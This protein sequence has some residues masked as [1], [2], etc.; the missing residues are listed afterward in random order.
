MA[1]GAANW[2][3]KVLGALR[4]ELD[5]RLSTRFKIRT[6]A[7]LLR[8][9]QRN[10]EPIFYPGPGDAGL[11]AARGRCLITKARSELGYEPAID[12][13]KGMALTEEYVRAKYL[14]QA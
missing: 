10:N 12:L 1:G 9:T 11:Y 8:L 6:K 2:P 14:R 5:R 13:A 4:R 7:V 3:A